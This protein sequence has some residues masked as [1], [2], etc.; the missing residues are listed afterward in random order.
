MHCNHLSQ[1]ELTNAHKCGEVLFGD[2]TEYREG[3]IIRMV[4]R[5]QR[6]TGS[7]VVTTSYN[8]ATKQIY[9]FK[10][11]TWTRSIVQKVSAAFHAPRKSLDLPQHRSSGTTLAC[12]PSDK[13]SPQPQQSLHLM[14]CMQR[15]RYRRTVRQDCIDGV[16]TDQT[17]FRYLQKQVAR[18]RGRVRKMFSLKCIQ[19]MYFVKVSWEASQIYPR[20]LC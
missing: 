7:K 10:A 2:V 6:S 4:E 12:V 3:G 20:Y 14:A 11:P 1:G 17:L 8:Q 13:N 15:G 18:H 5:I 16:T 9:T 19:G